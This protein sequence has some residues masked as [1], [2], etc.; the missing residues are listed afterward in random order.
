MK[1][2]AGGAHECRCVGITCHVILVHIYR[3]G[4][5]AAT[6][7]Q[8]DGVRGWLARGKGMVFARVGKGKGMCKSSWSR[9]ALRRKGTYSM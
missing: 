3:G 4:K 5:H 1:G 6:Q 8:V 7:R 9:E 2:C